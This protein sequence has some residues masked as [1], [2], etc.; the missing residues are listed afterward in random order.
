LPLQSRSSG[1]FGS[2]SR[3]KDVARYPKSKEANL[4]GNRGES[5]MLELWVTASFLTNGEGSEISPERTTDSFLINF[6]LHLTE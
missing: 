1:I 2:F 5:K 4:N 6:F 3:Q